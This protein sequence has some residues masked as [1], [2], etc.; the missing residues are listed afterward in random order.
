MQSAYKSSMHVMA[1]E[2][3]CGFLYFL[4]LFGTAA[5]KL[6]ELYHTASLAGE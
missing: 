2:M 3:Q 1:E 5:L 4:E 6:V